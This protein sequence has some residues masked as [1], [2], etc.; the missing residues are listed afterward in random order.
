MQFKDHILGKGV[1]G[2]RGRSSYFLSLHAFA[3]LSLRFD[4]SNLSQGLEHTRLDCLLHSNE[5]VIRG[6]ERRN[7]GWAGL[8]E[9]QT[10]RD[11]YY[12]IGR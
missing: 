2:S 5:V 12:E 7:E 1:K 8:E 9:L 10:K 6:K 4:Y 3:F 11:N